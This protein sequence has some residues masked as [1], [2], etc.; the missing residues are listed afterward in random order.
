MVGLLNNEDQLEEERVKAKEIREKMSGIV[1]GSAYGG[2]SGY[3]GS[4]S[5]GGSGGYGGSSG[6]GYGN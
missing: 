3:G 4:G 5:Y 1:G 2:N 6:Y